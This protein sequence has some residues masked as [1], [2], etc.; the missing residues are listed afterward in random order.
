MTK[1]DNPIHIAAHKLKSPLSFIYSSADLLLTGIEGELNDQQKDMLQR[2]L[3]HAE[4][5]IKI[6]EEILG[7][8]A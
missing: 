8:N 2:I 6:V 5:G 3:K 7:D 1:I 4:E